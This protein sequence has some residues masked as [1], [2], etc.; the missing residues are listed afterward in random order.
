MAERLSN[1]ELRKFG[2]TVGGAFVVLAAVSWWRGHELPP[3]VLATLGVAL[4]VPGLVFPSLLGPVQR[5]WM[6]LAMVLG[7]VNTRII[8]TVVYY[9]VMTPVGLVMRLFHDPLDRTLTD[10]RT[11]QWMRRTP[12]PVELGR[13]ERQ[14]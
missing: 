11:S 8:L 14:F 7:H 13:Y 1:A 12:Q 3:R 5:A 4:L 2:L 6:G 10:G 9:A